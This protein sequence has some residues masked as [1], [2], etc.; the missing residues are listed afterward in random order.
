MF[1]P[2][3]KPNERKIQELSNEFCRRVCRDELPLKIIRKNWAAT[4]KV[5]WCPDGKP[6]RSIGL[7]PVA[8]SLGGGT[9]W[10]ENWDTNRR[11]SV[12]SYPN[13]IY[14]IHRQVSDD[15]TGVICSQRRNAA[16]EAA[17]EMTKGATEDAAW[18]SMMSAAPFVRLEAYVEAHGLL[19][20]MAR[21]RAVRSAVSDAVEHAMA[22][23]RFILVEDLM[24]NDGYDKGNPFKVL[25]DGIY[26][27]GYWFIGPVKGKTVIFVP[28]IKKAA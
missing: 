26:D 9:V 24:P 5:I 8:S 3:E 1:Q 17:S 18:K 12:D 28:K 15:V 10:H 13:S 2:R 14:D 19:S 22:A 6:K 11:I 4:R 21:Y 16:G 27:K 23:A 20:K 7:V 25:F